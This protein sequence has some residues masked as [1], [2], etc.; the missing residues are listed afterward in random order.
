[1]SV[2][3]V[4]STGLDDVETPFGK[5]R[6]ALGGSAF[7]AATAA[8]LFAPTA[9][10]GIVGDDFPQ[11]HLRFLRKRRID[12]S[13]LEIVKGGKT[14][15][16]SGRYHRDIN[17]RDTL[18]LQL[19]TFLQ[20]SPTLNAAARQKRFVFLANIDPE[21]HLKVL[22]QANPSAFVVAD[23]M[24]HWIRDRLPALKRSLKKVDALV[25]NDGEARQLTGEDNLIKAAKLAARLGP[26]IV[27]I[28]KGEHGAILWDGEEIF[29]A[30]A[31]PLE[32]VVDPTGAGDTFAGALIGHLARCGKV[33]G[34]EL[35]RAVIYGT[36]VASFTCEAFSTEKLAKIGKKDIETRFRQ[37]KRIA[38]F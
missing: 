24:D 6:N 34:A 30:P 16:W 20:F 21:L 18:D 25:V 5:R 2:L 12:L 8:S 22:A 38:E 23:T 3:I 15:H 10:L 1:M 19:N 28:K 31:C 4:G 29:S 9:L 27:L 33:G 14:F 35:R 36:V 26:K 17:K 7:Y 13:G 11:R 37:L 32:R